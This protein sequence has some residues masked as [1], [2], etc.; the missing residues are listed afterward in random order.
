MQTGLWGNPVWRMPPDRS[1]IAV[2]IVS[3]KVVLDHRTVLGADGRTPEESEVESFRITSQRA[4]S[5]YGERPKPYV[6]YVPVYGITVPYKEPRDGVYGYRV[7]S[8][9]LLWATGIENCIGKLGRCSLEFLCNTM[10]GQVV[11]V[12]L[13]HSLH[14]G[15]VFDFIDSS[16][17]RPV[18]D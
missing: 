5:E 10:V 17:F 13:Y 8:D 15:L 16:T 14:D 7:T 2:R 9:D 3:A 18:P 4:N 11:L 6:Q 1:W 12:D